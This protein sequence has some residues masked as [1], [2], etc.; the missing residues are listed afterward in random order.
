MI[1]MMMY[2]ALHNPTVPVNT[3]RGAAIAAQARAYLEQYP[4][5]EIE[6]DD[7]DAV[8]INNVYLINIL[9][10]FFRYCNVF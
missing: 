3:K 9:V 7:I 8:R 1:T 2:D 6:Q 10:E 5:E 4:Y